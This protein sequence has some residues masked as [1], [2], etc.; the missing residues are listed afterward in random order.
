M[1]VSSSFILDT[2]YA[3]AKG[4]DEPCSYLN[5]N[6]LKISYNEAT[7]KAVCQTTEQVFG[8]DFPVPDKCGRIAGLYLTDKSCQ[9][10]PPPQAVRV[11]AIAPANTMFLIFF[12]VR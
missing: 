4:P 10:P 2:N 5:D 8:I 3:E 11:V 6:Y 9:P 7:R 1:I 12:I